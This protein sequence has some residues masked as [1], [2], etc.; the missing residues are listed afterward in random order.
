LLSDHDT[1]TDPDGSRQ[2][3][4]QASSTDKQLHI[5]T[6]MWHILTKEPGN[7]KILAQVIAWIQERL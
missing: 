6:D 5:V 7:D 1:M 2:L 3:V 4:G